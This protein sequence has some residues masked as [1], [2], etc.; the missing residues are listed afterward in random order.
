MRAKR[1]INDHRPRAGSFG[2]QPSC[3][4]TIFIQFHGPRATNQ[5][6]LR[7]KKDYVIWTKTTHLG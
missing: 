2:S 4:G 3:A 6:Y 5:D 1:K 7:Q